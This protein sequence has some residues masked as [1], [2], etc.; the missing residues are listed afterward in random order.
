VALTNPPTVLFLD[1]FGKRIK[2]EEKSQL[3]RHPRLPDVAKA[4]KIRRVFI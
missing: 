3:G 2:R 4:I 1:S